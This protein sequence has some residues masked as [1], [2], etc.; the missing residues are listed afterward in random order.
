MVTAKTI[1]AESLGVGKLQTFV[2]RKFSESWT[3]SN[4]VFFI[5]GETV[6]G[7]F[8]VAELTEI[9]EGRIL[10]LTEDDANIR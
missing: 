10:L 9:L 2:H 8:S 7:V 1:A 4:P 5:T 3:A 6:G